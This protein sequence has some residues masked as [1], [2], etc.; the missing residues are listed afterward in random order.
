M[1]R[2]LPELSVTTFYTFVHEFSPPSPLHRRPP[3]ILVDSNADF[4]MSGCRFEVPVAVF[5]SRRPTRAHVG[6]C[7]VD[8]SRPIASVP[9]GNQ[10]LAGLAVTLPVCF[11]SCLAGLLP[12][13]FKLLGD[14]VPVL[15]V[16]LV[17][18]LPLER[19]LR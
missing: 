15:E 19:R 11:R 18:R 12:G 7:Q 4:G 9:A 8:A 10:K 6:Y 5:P 16:H 1:L 17:R 3:R 14:V 13:G 2:P